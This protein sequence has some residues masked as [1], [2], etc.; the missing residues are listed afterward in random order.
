[1]SEKKYNPA[2]RLHQLMVKLQSTDKKLPV[3]EAW[4]DIFSLQDRDLKLIF[5]GAFQLRKLARETRTRVE[6]TENIT[7]SKFLAHFNQIE[8]FIDGMIKYPS[9]PLGQI[10]QPSSISLRDIEFIEEI[11]DKNPYSEK[12]IADDILSSIQTD[13]LEV[14]QTTLNSSLDDEIKTLITGQ[15]NFIENAICMY[16]ISGSSHALMN[17][18]ARNMGISIIESPKLTAEVKETSAFQSLKKL[19]TRIFSL[20]SDAN[21]LAKL[22]EMVAKLLT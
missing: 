7:H 21:N 16:R 3:I 5:D 11:L 22:S 6:K 14:R 2:K 12:E 17:A 4:K 1:M 8:N 13:L 20:I 9:S 18:I 15:L 19:H 10:A